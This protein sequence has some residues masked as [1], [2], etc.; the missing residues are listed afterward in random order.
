MSRILS[1]PFPSNLNPLSNSTFKFSIQKIPEINYFLQQVELP[2]IVLGE[3]TQMSSFS[4]IP[5]PG[6]RVS[7]SPLNISFMIDS[8]MQN[9][10]SIFNWIQGQGFPE[11]H[12][13]FKGSSES[14]SDGTLQILDGYSNQIAAIQFVDLVPTSLSGLQFESTVDDVVYLI[15]RATFRYTVFRFL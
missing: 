3:T 10:R 9:Y 11:G 2:D 5:I 15:G 12:Q 1:C 4:D 8:D 14:Y 6:D 7:F 13:Q